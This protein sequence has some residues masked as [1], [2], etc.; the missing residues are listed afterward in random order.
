MFTL[1][2]IEARLQV[3][4]LHLWRGV[5]TSSH[6]M[7]GNHTLITWLPSLTLQMCRLLTAGVC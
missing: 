1:H 3:T 5:T 4:V 2:N 7:F 6:T